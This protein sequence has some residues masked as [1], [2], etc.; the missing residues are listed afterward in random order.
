MW[1]FQ[2]NPIICE[3]DLS[4]H[5]SGN[6]PGILLVL[7]TGVGRLLSTGYLA[8]HTLQLCLG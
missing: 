8:R 3:W 5:L 7:Q 2:T 6:K 4:V 1:E